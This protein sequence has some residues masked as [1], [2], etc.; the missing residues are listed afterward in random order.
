MR[1]KIGHKY[2]GK[3]CPTF[4]IAEVGSNHNQD[5]D[6]AIKHIESAAESGVD[7]VKFQTFKAD[8][9]IS[10][11]AEIPDYLKDCKNIHSL[12]ESLELNRDWQ[13]PLKKYAESKGLVFLSSPCDYDAVDGLEEIRVA[14]HKV[15]SFDL[16]DLDLIR[17]IAKTKKPILLS[18]GLSNWMEIQRAVDVCREEGNEKIILLQCTSLYP[19]PA[20]L[21]NLM[22]IKT[23]RNAYKVI[24]GYSDHTIGDSISMVSVAMGAAI[25]EKHFTLDRSLPGPDHSFAMEPYELKTMVKKIREVEK[26]IGDGSKAGPREQELDMYKKVRRSLHAKVSIKKGEVI[27]EEMLTSKRPGFGITIHLNSSIIGRNAR[28]DIEKDRWILWDYI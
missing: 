17:Y 18:T 14:A 9:H 6:L 26:A 24:T 7:A 10:K 25:I 1:I 23:M 13:K 12:I 27:T 2:I 20:N 4:I 16:P 8:K 28:C 5:F 19:A 3:D 15:A 21:S 22:A 11:Y